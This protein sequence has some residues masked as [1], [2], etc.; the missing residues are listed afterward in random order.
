MDKLKISPPWQ[1]FAKKVEALFE[2]DAE[3]EVDMIDDEAKVLNIDVYS[4]KKY[5][6]LIQLLPRTKTFGNVVLNIEI[7]NMT[8]LNDGKVNYAELFGTLFEGNVSAKNVVTVKDLTGTEHVFVIFY[9]EVKQFFNDNLFD[10]NGF[11]TG[12]SQDIAA[13]VFEEAAENRV[14]FC[15]ADVR[16]N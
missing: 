15:T 11:W 3:I 10:Y 2:N 9:P 6:A 16:E 8:A 7:N 14:H 4:T 13:E 12:L 1:T 5:E